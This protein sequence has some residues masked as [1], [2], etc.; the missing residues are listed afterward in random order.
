[1]DRNSIKIARQLVTIAR[2][3]MA[4][5][6]TYSFGKDCVIL[7]IEGRDWKQFGNRTYWVEIVDLL[8]E[9]CK[10][11]FYGIDNSCRE[12]MTDG[13]ES[14]KLT[15]DGRND[16]THKSPRTMIENDLRT[17]GFEEEKNSI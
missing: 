10:G 8:D 17:L 4:G 1:M 6:K 16:A 3:L 15:F 9:Q 12:I 13:R 14:V 7:T 2:S 5:N 11:T